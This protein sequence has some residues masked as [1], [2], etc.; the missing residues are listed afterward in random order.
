MG[1]QPKRKTSQGRR[2]NRRSHHALSEPSLSKCPKCGEAKR[3]HFACE[4]CGYY[5]DGADLKAK[6]TK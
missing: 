5:G 3:N 4:N 1:A 2:N 6:K